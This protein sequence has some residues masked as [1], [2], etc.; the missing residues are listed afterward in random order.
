MSIDDLKNKAEDT[1]GKVKENAGEVTGNEDLANEG[2][3]DQVK[4]DVKDAVNDVK[5]KATNVANKILGNS[6]E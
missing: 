3:A 1:A 5:E 6:K 2:R 4:S